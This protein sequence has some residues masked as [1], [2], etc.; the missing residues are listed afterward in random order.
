[1]RYQ[2]NGWTQQVRQRNPMPV[3]IIPVLFYHGE[4][5]WPLK[6]WPEY[7]HGWDDAFEPY[8]PNGGYVLVDLSE[9]DDEQIM[10]FRSGFLKNALMMMKH[11]KEREFLLENL[12]LIFNFVEAERVPES[13]RVEFLKIALRYL[14]AL[15]IIKPGEIK[16]KLQSLMFTSQVWD[17][18]EEVK[19]EGF[20]EGIEE[21]IEKGIDLEAR[22]IIASLIRHLPEANDETIANL[23]SKPASLVAQVRQDIETENS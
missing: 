6:S 5:T 12:V 22:S 9:M 16:S 21:G 1:M 20:E 19:A 7:L 4:D 23:S 15:N 13:V 14:Q 8:T 18:L 17:V 10:H 3:P 2:Q 11:R